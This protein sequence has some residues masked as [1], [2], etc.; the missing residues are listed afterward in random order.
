MRIRRISSSFIPRA[1][2]GHGILRP[3]ASLYARR[4]DRIF[5]IALIESV[6][7]AHRAFS[8]WGILAAGSATGAR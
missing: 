3:V 7:S 5:E 1:F 6:C 2:A 4:R 8:P